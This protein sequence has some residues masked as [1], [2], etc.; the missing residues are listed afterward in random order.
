M[1]PFAASIRNLRRLGS[2]LLA[3]DLLLRGGLLL[4]L[5]LA[6]GGDTGDSSLAQVSAVAVLGSLVGDG[7]VGAIEKASR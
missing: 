3:T 1:T 7:L 2:S 4:L 5:G 6:D